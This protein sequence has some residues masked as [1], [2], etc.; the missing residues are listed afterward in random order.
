MAFEGESWRWLIPL[1]SWLREIDIAGKKKNAGTIFIKMTQF[2]RIKC[3]MN[4]MPFFSF[5][6]W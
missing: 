4:L 2:N 5:A 6:D 1:I 3:C